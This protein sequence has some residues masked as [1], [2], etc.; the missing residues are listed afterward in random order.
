ME[1]FVGDL[2][3]R[4][5]FVEGVLDMVEAEI[6]VELWGHQGYEKAIDVWRAK[7]LRGLLS[8]WSEFVHEE[9]GPRGW[10]MRLYC[11]GVVQGMSRRGK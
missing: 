11:L 7:C 4:G 9:E 8:N 5:A 3:P 1:G 10:L 2:D 6:P